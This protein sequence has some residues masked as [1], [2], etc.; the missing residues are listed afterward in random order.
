MGALPRVDTAIIG[1]SGLY[2]MAGLDDVRE[3]SVYT[4][5]GPP[6]DAIRVGRIG[7]RR[8]AFLARHGD[9]HR[10]LP[11]EIDFRANIFALKLLGVERIF[12]AS[13][14]GSLRESI[15]PREVV[16][17]D[18]F[19][20][21]APHRPATFFGGGIVAHISFADPICAASRAILL[22]AA[23]QLGAQAHDGGTY[24]CMDGPAFSTRA[25]STL[26]RS[27]GADVI[28]MT[29]LQEAK[30]AREAEICYATLAL[31]T[32]YDCWHVE[33][34]DVSVGE[35]LGNLR[36]NAKLSSEIL[37]AAVEQTPQNRDGCGCGEAL[38]DAILTD[39]TRAPA[40]T[41]ERLRAIVGRYC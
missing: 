6:S 4:P 33:E 27:W 40:E 10:M 17:I 29:N 2:A 12:S 5:F 39:L 38:K 1:G 20:D 23:R 9:G 3:V 18:Q 25:E 28:G 24:L 8:V 7:A 14:V 21:R 13:A 35:L 22:A 15:H 32:D 26:Y 37:R 36:A 19:I 11:A 34:N 30:L 41:M 31:V 16:L